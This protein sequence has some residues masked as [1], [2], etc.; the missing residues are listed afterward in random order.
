ML[1][2][3]AIRIGATL[4]TIASLSAAGIM[5]FGG[6][7]PSSASPEHGNGKGIPA[8]LVLTPSGG[9]STTT[10]SLTGYDF[11][12]SSSTSTGSQSSGAGAG[13]VTFSSLVVTTTPGSQTAS[14]FADLSGN[15]PFSQAEL[16][17]PGTHGETL[18]DVTFKLVLLDK[19]EESSSNGGTESLT[20]EYGA[21]QLAQVTSNP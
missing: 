10:V 5:I 12:E 9:G 18:L 7:V 3:R 2:T 20:F 21:L 13:K 17:V 8:T 11:A 4:V 6:G 1:R 19:I 14:F 16:I 15:A